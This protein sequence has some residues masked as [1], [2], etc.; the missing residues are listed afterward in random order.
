VICGAD[1]QSSADIAS[2]AEAL[3]LDFGTTVNDWLVDKGFVEASPQER[4]GIV[5]TRNAVTPVWGWRA[6][7]VDDLAGFLPVLRNPRLVYV[8]QDPLA[9]SLANPDA[10]G[11]ALTGLA[12]TVDDQM[13][14][15]GTVAGGSY[16][17]FVV[18]VESARSAP[19]RFMQAL[20]AFMGMTLPANLRPAIKVLKPARQSKLAN[21][22]EGAAGKAPTTVAPKRPNAEQ[23]AR[24]QQLRA[25]RQQ[26][27]QG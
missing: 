12:R 15:L 22:T 10:S 1:G 6:R 7:P 18:S 20:A 13:N 3:G 11:D 21:K 23:R 9:R 17:V 25:Q 16:P 26:K 14:R 8:W 4:A 24:R 19:R 27:K 5:R 2:V